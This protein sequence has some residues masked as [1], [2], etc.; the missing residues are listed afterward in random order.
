[1]VGQNE[2]GYCSNECFDKNNSNKPT[3]S[4]RKRISK[5][6]SK[7][8]E[9]LSPTTT[10]PLQDVTCTAKNGKKCIFPFKLKDGIERNTC[11]KVD[12]ANEKYYCSIKVDKNGNHVSGRAGVTWGYCNNNCPREFDENCKTT[13]DSKVPNENCVFPFVYK[14]VKHHNCVR[15]KLPNTFGRYWCPTEV[16][17]DGS[18][19]EDKWGFCLLDCVQHM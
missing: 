4:T 3:S 13:E 16:G 2:Y 15:G 19:S 17:S 1:M 14:G 8:A 10:P 6:S 12:D 7:R 5:P 9:G 11:T 18:F